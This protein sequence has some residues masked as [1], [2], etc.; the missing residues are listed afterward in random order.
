MEILKLK[1]RYAP[2]YIYRCIYIKQIDIY[3]I[4]I[5]THIYKR[6]DINGEPLWNEWA[7]GDTYGNN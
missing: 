6:T 1:K 3:N 5:D 2:I 4:H 7:T